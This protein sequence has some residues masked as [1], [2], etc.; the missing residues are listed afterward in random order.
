MSPLFP[1]S[2]SDMPHALKS[3]ATVTQWHPHPKH[4]NTKTWPQSYNPEDGHGM[5]LL[6]SVSKR[7][8]PQPQDY[9]CT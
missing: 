6:P 7:L 4:F 1:F 9:E 2:I 5:F 3:A 8:T